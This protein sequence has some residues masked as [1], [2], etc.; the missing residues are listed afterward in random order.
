MNQSR[1]NMNQ[2]MSSVKQQQQKEAKEA[3]EGLDKELSERLAESEDFQEMKKEL[4]DMGY[5]EKG[6]TRTDLRD[7]ETEFKY[8]YE[9]PDGEKGEIT[10]KMKDGKIE[11]LKKFSDDDAKALDE[12]LSSDKEIIY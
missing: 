1:Q 4:E 9:K 12:K 11:D 7:N 8:E 6:K 5:E 3:N 2:D 10:G